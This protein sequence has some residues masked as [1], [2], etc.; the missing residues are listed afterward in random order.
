MSERFFGPLFYWFTEGYEK[1]AV[2]IR[3]PLDVSPSCVGNNATTAF[4]YLLYRNC[5]IHQYMWCSWHLLHEHPR[6]SPEG[7]DTWRIKKNIYILLQDKICLV[8]LSLSHMVQQHLQRERIL[9]NR[10]NFS[11]PSHS[12]TWPPPAPT[13]SWPWSL[14]SRSD[15]RT[16]RRK[17]RQTASVQCC[18]ETKGTS[19]EQLGREPGWLL[20]HPALLRGGDRPEKR[21]ASPRLGDTRLLDRLGTGTSETG[22]KWQ[23]TLGERPV[24]IW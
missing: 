18:G 2:K 7:F 10:G 15:R 12:P 14:G 24:A 16:S 19:K 21:S 1:D 23:V 6:V 20:S 11:S 5:K 17:R 9:E 4:E 22:R 3:R 13:L 8:W